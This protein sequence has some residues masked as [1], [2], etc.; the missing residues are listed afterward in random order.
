MRQEVDDVQSSGSARERRTKG[1]ELRFQLGEGLGQIRR[2]ETPSALGR[3][4]DVGVALCV[5]EVAAPPA[6][7]AGQEAPRLGVVHPP[8]Q[9]G[10]VGAVAVPEVVHT[11]DV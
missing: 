5:G 11:I 3:L 2:S 1:L 8:Q 10:I 6:L 4:P 9:L 7:V